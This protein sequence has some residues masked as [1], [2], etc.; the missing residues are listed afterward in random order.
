M[1]NYDLKGT[2]DGN[3]LGAKERFEDNLFDWYIADNHYVASEKC[4]HIIE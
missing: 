4:L 2:H 3:W 1:I